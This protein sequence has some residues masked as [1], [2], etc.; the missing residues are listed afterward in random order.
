MKSLIIFP[1]VIIVGMALLSQMGLSTFETSG[2]SAYQDYNGLFDE[3]GHQ[4][5]DLNGTAVG[6]SGYLRHKWGVGVT[7]TWWNNVTGTYLTY[8]TPNGVNYDFNV[9]GFNMGSSLGVIGL[10]VAIIALATIAGLKI[11]GSGVGE[12]S[13]QTIVVATSFVSLWA[14]FSLMSMNLITQIPIFGVPFYFFITIMYAI[15]IFSSISAGGT[16]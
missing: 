2:E 5:S 12:F 4:V 8:N 11:L 9:L 7:E 13:V 10:V 14:L 3:N 16:D 15:G 6:E 1:L